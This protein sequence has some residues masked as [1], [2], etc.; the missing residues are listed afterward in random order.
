MKSRYEVEGEILAKQAIENLRVKR[1]EPP[2]APRA[3]PAMLDRG[4]MEA[5]A[6][7]ERVIAERDAQ[8]A[9]LRVDAE[10]QR[11]F[12]ETEREFDT[13]ALAELKGLRAQH[14]AAVA[15]A[16]AAQEE[17]RQLGEGLLAEVLAVALEVGRPIAEAADAAIDRLIK[18]AAVHQATAWRIKQTAVEWQELA[19]NRPPYWQSLD[20]LAQLEHAIRGLGHGRYAEAKRRLPELRERLA[21]RQ[22]ELDAAAA[23]PSPPPV[24]PA[25]PAAPPAD[26]APKRMNVAD[27]M[28]ITS[29]ITGKSSGELIEELTGEIE[30]AAGGGDPEPASPEDA[31]AGHA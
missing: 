27:M 26:A 24:A 5:I 11:R 3:R 4:C 21:R 20:T 31:E 8:I 23:P 29:M 28:G 9:Q 7:Y 22:A 12:V 17:I 16:T 2:P 18:V 6:Q 19:D 30:A 25:A 10:R 15:R 14:E 13:A 1:E